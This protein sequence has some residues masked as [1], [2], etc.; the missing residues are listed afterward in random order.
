MKKV[1]VFAVSALVFSATASFAQD[2]TRTEYIQKEGEEARE[3]SEEQDMKG[4][5][6]VNSADIPAPLR[7]TLG[8]SQYRGWEKSTVYQNDVTKRYMVRVGDENPTTY[9][10]DKEGKPV[11]DPGDKR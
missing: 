3:K 11:D 5:T 7:T 4:W 9:Y 8:G 10:F 2:T 6:K 1:I